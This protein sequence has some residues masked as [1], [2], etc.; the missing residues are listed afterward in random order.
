L[1]EVVLEAEVTCPRC[2]A[3][4]RLMR[5]ICNDL[6]IPFSV[7][8]NTP[9]SI[10]Y[11]DTTAFHTFSKEWIERFGSEEQKEKLKDVEKVLNFIQRE[12]I[13][14][15]P[16]LRIRVATGGRLQEIVIRGYD[17]SKEREFV[18]NIYALLRV[19]KRAAYGRG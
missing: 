15:Y 17:P 6:N 14:M 8:Y 9:Y 3:L 13:N 10:F 4:Y 5:K 18:A 12:H 2:A 19:L 1:I 7:R 11:E 16:V